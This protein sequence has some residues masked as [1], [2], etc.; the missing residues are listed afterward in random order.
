MNLDNV[1]ICARGG[2]EEG[3][4]FKLTS[5]SHGVI[6]VTGRHNIY[7]TICTLKFRA[8]SQTKPKSISRERQRHTAIPIDKSRRTHEYRL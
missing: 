8:R 4:R 1:Q 2:R 3:K 5:E 6:D 7:N